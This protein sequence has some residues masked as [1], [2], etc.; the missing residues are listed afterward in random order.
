MIIM[1][2]CVVSTP[3]YINVPM[4]VLFSLMIVGIGVAEGKMSSFECEN[5]VETKSMCHAVYL[6]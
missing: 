2:S 5:S 4:E 1:F 3:F 6:A